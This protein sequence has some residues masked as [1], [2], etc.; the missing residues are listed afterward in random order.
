MGYMYDLDPA[1]IPQVN[2][3]PPKNATKSFGDVWAE[4]A[5]GFG[6][7]IN[8]INGTKALNEFN[9]QEAQKAR[10]FNARQAELQRQYEERLSNTTYQRTLADMKAAG[11]NPAMLSGLTGGNLVSTPSGSS[12]SGH[13]A[14]SSSSSSGTALLNTVLG[15]LGLMLG[16]KLGASSKT[17]IINRR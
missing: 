5:A 17:V 3:T 10:D 11:I 6:D 12:A 7:W 8:T 1:P 4:G 16:R 13:G 9:A 2:P 15:T 14:S